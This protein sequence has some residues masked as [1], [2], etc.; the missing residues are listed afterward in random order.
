MPRPAKGTTR[1][2]TTMVITSAPTSSLDLGERSSF[3]SRGSS[4]G[5]SV[6]RRDAA[7]T[8]V[9]IARRDPAMSSTSSI[10]LFGM[11]S[12]IFVKNEASA[13]PSAL[14]KKTLDS[15]VSPMTI[16]RMT[17]TIGGFRYCLR[18]ARKAPTLAK[19][20]ISVVSFTLSSLTNMLYP[21][22]HSAGDQAMRKSAVYPA[23][24]S[25]W[26][27]VSSVEKKIRGSVT[28]FPKAQVAFT[29]LFMT[30]AVFLS[31]SKSAEPPA[32]DSAL[33]P[34]TIAP[35]DAK[36]IAGCR[37]SAGTRNLSARLYRTAPAA[38]PTPICRN[39]RMG[40]PSME[41]SPSWMSV[42]A[43]LEHRRQ[44]S[45]T[46]NATL[47]RITGVSLG[48]IWIF[49]RREITP[50]RST[51]LKVVE[52]AEESA[53]WSKLAKKDL[54]AAGDFLRPRVRFGSMLAPEGAEGDTSAPPL[55][56]TPAEHPAVL[57]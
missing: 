2:L 11:P 50:Q 47:L 10:A 15:G 28:E 18:D 42:T 37:T 24:R 22:D 35:P 52:H 8:I 44:G 20:D 16:P 49:I 30:L 33:P 7:R 41:G 51:S 4:F 56:R 29:M 21:R 14:G 13:S 3:Q 19:A 57:T 9:W 26:A 46:L 36:A 5:P 40:T 12:I 25:Y 39:P 53:T 17:P 23:A 54:G 48:S 43:T 6:G 45:R 38:R 27:F 55:Q 34:S 1:N 31:A 32:A